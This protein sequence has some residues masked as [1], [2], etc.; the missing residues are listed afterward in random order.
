MRALPLILALALSSSLVLAGTAPAGA[1]APQAPQS[2]VPQ[3]VRLD[4]TITDTYTGEPATKTVSMVIETGQSGMIRTSN[5]LPNGQPLG[6]NVDA[7]ASVWPGSDAI[8]MR[9]TFEYTPAQRSDSSPSGSPRPAELHESLSV[10]LRD[11]QPMTVSQS[12]DPATDRTVTVELTAT[13][14]R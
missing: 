4:L 8:R 2:P 5:R 13:I 6:L 7:H 9:V 3:N 11:G 12:A 14:L 10:V 1:P